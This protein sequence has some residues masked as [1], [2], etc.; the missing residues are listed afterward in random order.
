MEVDPTPGSATAK[1]VASESVVVAIEFS[2]V[3]VIVVAVVAVVVSVVVVVAAGVVD[4]HGDDGQEDGDEDEEDV[5]PK[6][7]KVPKVRGKYGEDDELLPHLHVAV[8]ELP[9]IGS[10]TLDV[11][12][13]GKQVDVKHKRRSKSMFVFGLK[14]ISA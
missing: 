14:E 2:V 3:A 6:A 4:E 5:V 9:K 13:S 10:R 12:S 1:V 8:E 7:P 11:S